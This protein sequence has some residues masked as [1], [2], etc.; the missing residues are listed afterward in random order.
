VTD[1]PNP[2][3]NSNSNS[4]P[5]LGIAKEPIDM[6]FLKST[7]MERLKK[8]SVWSTAKVKK[9]KSIKSIPIDLTT[10]PNSDIIEEKQVEIPMDI[11]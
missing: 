10:N 4:N 8:E 11:S 5:N 6:K 1:N 2:N 7:C 3:P 9:P